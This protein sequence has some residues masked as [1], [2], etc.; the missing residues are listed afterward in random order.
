VI[1]VLRWREKVSRLRAP[2][3]AREQRPEGERRGR[4]K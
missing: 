4:R 1:S 3:A 2:E